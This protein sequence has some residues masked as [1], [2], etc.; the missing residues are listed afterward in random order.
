MSTPSLAAL[1]IIDAH[2]HFWDLRTN[3]HPWLRGPERIPFRYGDYSAICRDYLPPDYRTDTARYRVVGTVHMEAEIAHGDA[4]AETRWLEHLTAREGLPWACVAQTRLDAPD[5]VQILAQQ[6]SHAIV[7]GIR[8]KPT[9]ASAPGQVRPAMKGAMDDPAWRRGYAAL[10]DHRMSFDLQAPWW[11]AAQAAALAADFPDTPLIINHSFLPADRSQQGL[12]D[13]RD[14][15]RTV[16]EQPNVALK[17]SGLGLAGRPWRAAE[18]I[19]LIRDA[20]VIMGWER[21]MFAS[22]FP[23]DG[24]VATFDQVA[25]AFL[26]AIAD[27]PLCQVRALLHDNAVRIYRLDPQQAAATGAQTPH[28]SG[29]ET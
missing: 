18:N 5:A 11:H 13:W 24:L 20:I 17:I 27:R 3:H 14:A 19:P 9:A 21:C 2:Q 1:P 22:N 4:V 28:V 15:L 7:R 26:D 23:V 25:G 29:R 8:H 6:A 12:A 10:H 16:A